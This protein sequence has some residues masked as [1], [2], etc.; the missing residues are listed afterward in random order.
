MRRVEQAQQRPGLLLQR[1]FVGEV[2]TSQLGK[3]K[4]F[5]GREF[6]GQIELNGLAQGLR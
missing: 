4:L 5:V 3:A 2:N 6:P 1:G